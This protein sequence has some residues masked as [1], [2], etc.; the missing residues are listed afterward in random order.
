MVGIAVAG[1]Y[2]ALAMIAVGFG[3]ASA[4]AMLCMDRGEC[5][6]WLP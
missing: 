3:A 5:R 4:G 6:R 1:A 2:P